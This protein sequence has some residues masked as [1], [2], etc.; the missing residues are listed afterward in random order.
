M[1]L[2]EELRFESSPRSGFKTPNFSCTVQRAKHQRLS[3]TETTQA[4]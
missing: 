1:K 2:P 3:F 4:T